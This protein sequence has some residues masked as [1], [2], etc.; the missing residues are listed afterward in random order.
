MSDKPIYRQ[1]RLDRLRAVLP[2][3]GQRVRVELRGWKR[4]EDGPD[5][6]TGV[7]VAVATQAGSSTDALVLREDGNFAVV[8]S[9]ATVAW[10]RRVDG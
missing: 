5:V 4:S 9:L 7:L 3:E 8:F 10:V 2:Y 6:R 1:D